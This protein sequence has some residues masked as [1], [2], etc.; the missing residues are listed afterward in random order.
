MTL[1]YIRKMPNVDSGTGAFS[2][3][4]IPSASNAPRRG[5]M[6]PSS[7]RRAVE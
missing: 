1:L 6:I 4:E 7:Q 2:A 5:S 3:A